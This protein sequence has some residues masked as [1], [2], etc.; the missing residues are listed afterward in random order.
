VVVVRD[1]R[2]AFGVPAPGAPVPGDV[3]LAAR[4]ALWASAAGLVLFGLAWGWR[5]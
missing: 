5:G 2:A 3:P 4:V 1:A